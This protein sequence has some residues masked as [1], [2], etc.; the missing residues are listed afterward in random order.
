MLTTVNLIDIVSNYIFIIFSCKF[1]LSVNLN[2][3]VCEELPE[4][5]KS[6]SAKSLDSCDVMRS[7][8]NVMVVNVFNRNPPCGKG[9][10]V[11]IVYC[12]GTYCR[13]ETRSWENN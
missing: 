3:F 7:A 9:T 5:K 2:R 6:V 4:L 12:K 1:I 10:V 11:S 13:P 8:V